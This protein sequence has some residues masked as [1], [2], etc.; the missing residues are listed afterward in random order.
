MCKHVHPNVANERDPGRLRGA[1]VSIEAASLSQH[2]AL[3]FPPPA[4][5]S[6][7]SFTSVSQRPAHELCGG[8]DQLIESYCL[9]PR[10][11][12]EGGI[13]QLLLGARAQPSPCTWVRALR[14]WRAPRAHPGS[15]QHNQQL[16]ERLP[17]IDCRPSAIMF[18]L[19]TFRRL[20][21][22]N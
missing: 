12:I 7:S 18:P 15:R 11:I 22:S 13:T 16:P 2:R 5:S 19:F 1:A 4:A 6:S 3:I 8:I 9:K 20:P 17:R 14:R 10:V 21:H